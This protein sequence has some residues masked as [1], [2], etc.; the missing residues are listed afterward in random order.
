MGKKFERLDKVLKKIDL[1]ATGDFHKKAVARVGELIEQLTLQ[2]ITS[3]RNPRGRAWAP[4]ALTGQPAVTLSALAASSLKEVVDAITAR[5]TV[6]FPHAKAH[7]LGASRGKT[8][9]RSG[10]RYSGSELGK[11][12][13]RLYEHLKPHLERDPWKLPA[14][15]AL[16]RGNRL[17]PKWS[18][19]INAEMRQLFGATWD[20]Y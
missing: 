14:R 19:T 10:R 9:V 13:K 4:L 1:L 17:P 7:Q 3:L 12:S 16:P 18:E 8:D 2:S 6:H 11:M 5:L 15:S 20:S